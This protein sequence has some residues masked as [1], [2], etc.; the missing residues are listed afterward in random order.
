M[1]VIAE[2]SCDRSDMIVGIE[3]VLQNCPVLLGHFFMKKGKDSSVPAVWLSSC[4]VSLPYP[5][6][7]QR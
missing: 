2:F 7:P 4:W 3:V 1:S 6:I 5:F